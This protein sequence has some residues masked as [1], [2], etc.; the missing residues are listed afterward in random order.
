MRRRRRGPHAAPAAVTNPLT[1]A[2][3]ALHALN[4]STV[5]ILTP[6][7]ADVTKDVA[8]AFAKADLTVTTVASFNQTSDAVVSRIRPS[9][10]LSAVQASWRNGAANHSGWPRSCAHM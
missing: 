1:A 10:V 2:I 6:Y 4:A 8:D 9:S 5:A 7:T 3:R